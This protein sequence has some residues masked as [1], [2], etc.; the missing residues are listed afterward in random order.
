M[1]WFCGIVTSE[2][3][4]CGSDDR[5]STVK[6]D[7]DFFWDFPELFTELIAALCEVLFEEFWM[8]LSLPSREKAPYTVL[9][10]WDSFLELEDSNS[11]RKMVI[12]SNEIR[13]IVLEE[14]GTKHRESYT[15]NHIS[16]I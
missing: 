5:F 11:Q 4:P 7:T 3:I 12:V 1:N 8:K 10:V 15:G 14:V 9:E 6:K 13:L 16:L 2:C